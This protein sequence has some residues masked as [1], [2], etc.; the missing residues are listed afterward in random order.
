[1]TT[2]AT[3]LYSLLRA[4]EAEQGATLEARWE[5]VLG[6]D[7][8]GLEFALRFTSVLGLWRET[9]ESLRA[10]PPSAALSTRLKYAASWWAAIVMPRNQWNANDR[11]RL[12]A[13]PSFDMLEI[14]AEA[15]EELD[16]GPP[17]RP[18]TLEALRT[19]SEEWLDL[20][21]Q[22]NTLSKGLKVSLIECFERV[23]WLID[24]Q[25]MVGIAPVIDETDR[26]AGR[27]LRVGVA[28]GQPWREKVEKW[29]DLAAKV[30]SVAHTGNLAIGDAKDTLESITK[31]IEP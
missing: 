16:G 26:T 31:A 30:A 3:N 21:R 12:L 14:T 15:L 25:A 2:A 27:L 17:A 18:E 28:T 10:M 1:M 24:N 7:A 4:L 20:V 8:D 23:L 11:P 19:E 5:Q 22:S 29:L 6:A 13:P 9:V